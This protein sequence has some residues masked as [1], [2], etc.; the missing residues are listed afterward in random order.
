MQAVLFDLDETL[1]RRD[2]AIRKFIASQYERFSRAMGSVRPED[3][4]STFLAAE[5]DGRIDKA[6]VYPAFVQSLGLKGLNADE[7]LADYRQRYP[8][9]ATLNPGAADTLGA[10]HEQGFKLGI[11]TNGNAQVQ[12]GKIDAI[13]LRSLLSSVIISETV[14]LN[15]PDPA[16]FSLAANGL[17]LGVGDCMFV[18][19]NP[20]VDIVGADN[21]GMTGVWFRAG[22]SWPA[23][24]TPPR[25][26]ID[27]LPQCLPIVDAT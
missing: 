13:G 5:D 9:F 2:I 19:D 21:A 3:Y 16:I 14:G 22:G 8:S 20:A 24:L 7:L 1:I 23:M 4:A 11:V 12:N 10:L 18:G 27:A 6:K 26:E 17:G 15:K 25:F